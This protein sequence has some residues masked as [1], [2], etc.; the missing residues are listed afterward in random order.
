MVIVLVTD[1][2]NTNNNGTTIS[3][4]HFARALAQRG[5][6]IRVIACGE[7]SRSGMDQETGYEMFYVPELKIPIASRF[8]HKQHTLFAKP[9]RATLE[10]AIGGADA[11][12]IYQPWPLGSAAQRT[13]RRLGVPALAAFHVQP[14]N[15]TYNIG[16]GWFPPAAHLIYFL[17]Y[18]FF[19]RRFGHIH[20]P[21][22]FIAA[23]LRSHG[24]KAWLHV[25]SNGVHPEF[26]PGEGCK[27]HIEGEPFKVLMVGRLSPEKRQELLIRAVSKSRYADAIQ[28]CF[29]GR[30]PWEKKLRR[31]GRRLPRPPVFGY[32]DRRELVELIR[33]SDLYIHTSD[34]EIEGIACI[35]AFSCGLV[36]VISDS[37]HS[38]AMQFALS[39]ENLFK[40]GN[41]ASLAQRLDYWLEDAQRLKAAGERYA[42]YGREYSLTRSVKQMERVYAALP[43]RKKNGYCHTR[44]FKLVSRLF[45]TGIAIPLLHVWTRVVLGVRIQGAKNLRRLKGALTVCNHVHM[46]DSALVALALFP[47]KIVFPTLQ[48]NVNTLWPGKMV[49]LLGGIALPENTGELKTFF[50]EME[51]LLLKDRIV[52][53]FPEGELNPYDTRLR[54]FKKGAFH[55]AAQARVPLIP[56]SISFEPPRGLRRLIRRKPVMALHIGKPIHPVAMD[57]KTDSNLRM[58]AARE[59]MN[60]FLA[61]NYSAG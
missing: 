36:P 21:S 43:V 24:Y 46:L 32:Y 44:L 37:R 16:L 18:L 38:A 61:R 6:R 50:D 7:P 29:A 8:A 5:H 56:M 11:V 20:C 17:L 51:Y 27:T 28:L 25:I 22:K 52:H 47:R 33:G 13:A 42:S 34:I 57:S 3:A 26:C 58:H 35:E 55:L 31:M 9:V 30:G 10:K 48:K 4:M 14:E 41:A 40:A 59:Q 2:F 39:A 60:S 54:G 45:Y 12:H 53:F 49:R 1:T 23:Q 19:Y 15:I